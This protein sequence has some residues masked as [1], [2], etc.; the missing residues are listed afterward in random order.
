M[1]ATAAVEVVAAMAAEAE[2]AEA[3]MAAAVVGTVA[4][5]AVGMAIAIAARDVTR[6]ASGWFWKAK[7][8]SASGRAGA[9][10]FLSRC[11]LEHPA[12]FLA[13]VAATSS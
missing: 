6:P 2:A 13:D 11:Y 8:P 7:C 10:V 5:A 3:A 1:V 12:I 9:V 4:V